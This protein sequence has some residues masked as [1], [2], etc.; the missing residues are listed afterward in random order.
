LLDANIQKVL[1]LCHDQAILCAVQAIIQNMIACEDASQQQLH[2]LQSCGFGGL[3]RFAGPFKSASCAENAQLFVNCLEAM[4]ETCLHIEE[5][6]S[7]ITQYPSMLSVS[8]NMN[9]SSSMSSLT[10]GSPTEK[11]KVEIF[12]NIFSAAKKL[13]FLIFF[14]CYQFTL[15]DLGNTNL[16]SSK[17][18]TYN[19]TKMLKN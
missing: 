11:G 17:K 12:N 18:D 6:G 16:S 10:L 3:W 7:E 14:I 13:L 2:Y 1:N 9:L 5:D 19:E 15:F 4:V 8:S